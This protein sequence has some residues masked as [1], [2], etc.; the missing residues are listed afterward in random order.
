[1]GSDRCSQWD[2]PT[3]IRTGSSIERSL[4][5][6]HRTW[7]DHPTDRT[8]SLLLSRG[9][10]RTRA[11]GAGGPL[12]VPLSSPRSWL[13][14]SSCWVAGLRSTARPIRR[15]HS[16]AERPRCPQDP[17]ANR[18]QRPGSPGWIPGLDPRRQH[19]PRR[20]HLRVPR[21]SSATRPSCVAA[22][23]EDMRGD[24]DK[25]PC[26]PGESHPPALCYAD[27]HAAMVREL[28]DIQA[29]A[30]AFIAG[31]IASSNAEIDQGIAAGNDVRPSS[32]RSREQPATD[33][34]PVCPDAGPAQ[35]T[36]TSRHASRSP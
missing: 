32:S 30:T 14:V 25:A 29:P 7:T 26:V 8:M 24:H 13:S 3:S 31:D 18:S 33:G 19:V 36:L 10:P 1:M 35:A 20:R 9:S 21:R 2:P 5:L 27:V 23:A 34:R 12:Q 17:S 11:A 4:R 16:T 28:T 15:P 6:G 22:A